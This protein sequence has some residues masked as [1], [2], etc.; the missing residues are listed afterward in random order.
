MLIALGTDDG[1]VCPNSGGKYAVVLDST[2]SVRIGF[3]YAPNGSIETIGTGRITGAI[4]SGQTVYLD[5]TQGGG[6]VFDPNAVQP[7]PTYD[8]KVTSYMEY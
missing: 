7:V 4:D 3:V 8:F 1:S 6:I 5:N 2:N